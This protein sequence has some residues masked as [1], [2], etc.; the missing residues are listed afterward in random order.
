MTTIIG[1]G[2]AGLLAG[3]MLRHRSPLIVERQS[4]LP[5]NHSA[6]LRFRSPIVGDTLNIPFRK[7]TMIKTHLPWKNP[8]ADALAYSFKNGSQYRSDRSIISGTTTADRWIAPPDLISRMAER[9]DIKYGTPFLFNNKSSHPIISTL[10]MPTLMTLLK[11]PKQ[12]EFNYVTGVNVKA[13]IADCDAY[14]SLLVPNPDLPISRISIT[15]NELIVE[16]PGKITFA[17]LAVSMAADLIGIPPK[18]CSDIRTY[19]QH[20]AKIMPISDEERHAFMFWATD[21]FNIFSLG[22]FATWR[23]GLLMDDLVN[24]LRRIDHWITAG[25]YAIARHR[26][27]K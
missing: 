11:Y 6:V 17:G 4:A 1:A 15:G 16:L 3:N 7:V 24:D 13:T 23:P 5:N 12:P 14:I 9:L 20:Y 22:R 10:P 25:S 19:P 27:G 2:L 21:K 18:S 26:S 8:V